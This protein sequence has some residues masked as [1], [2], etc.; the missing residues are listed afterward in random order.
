MFYV[1]NYTPLY[2]KNTI[3]R[4][5]IMNIR[6]IVI[7]TVGTAIA[8][9]YYVGIIAYGSAVQVANDT[10]DKIASKLEI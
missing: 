3:E 5:F 4:N 6:N 1:K 10:M 9:P 8:I 7:G 2:E